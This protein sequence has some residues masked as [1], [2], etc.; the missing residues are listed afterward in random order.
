MDARDLKFTDEKDGSKTCAFDVLATSFG[1]NG[2]LVDQIGKRYSM[3][4]TPDAYKK[5]LDEGFVYYFKFPVTRPGAYEYRVALRDSIGGSVGA[6]SQ[7]VQV[8]E[9]TALTIHP[10]GAHEQRAFHPHLAVAA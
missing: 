4:L 10:G 8:P 2:Q 3:T 5:A 9:S 1:D 6:A 7:F